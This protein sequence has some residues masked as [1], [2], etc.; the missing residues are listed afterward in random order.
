MPCFKI[1]YAFVS[2]KS[3]PA[4]RSWSRTLDTGHRTRNFQLSSSLCLSVS[5]SLSVSLAGHIC[6]SAAFWEIATICFIFHVAAADAASVWLVCMYENVW[7]FTILRF[8]Q[9]HEQSFFPWL[10]KT[11]SFIWII[12]GKTKPNQKYHKAS[13][14]KKKTTYKFIY[15][16][17]WLL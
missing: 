13:S 11:Y 5:L 14:K 2:N 8:S 17:M 12:I 15:K 16:Y 3:Q 1:E 6:V 7:K 9:N 10:G 4:A